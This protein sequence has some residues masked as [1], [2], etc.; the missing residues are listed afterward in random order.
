MLNQPLVS[1]IVP[2]YNAGEYIEMCMDAIKASSYPSFEII[3]VDDCSTDNSVEIARQ[4]GI[5][6]LRLSRQS[7]PAAARNFGAISL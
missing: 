2:V 1:V 4:K 3:M 5:T 6:V 7:G